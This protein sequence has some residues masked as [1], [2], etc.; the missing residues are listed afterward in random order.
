MAA[1]EKVAWMGELHSEVVRD[2]MKNRKTLLDSRK[3]TKRDDCRVAWQLARK[4]MPRVAD[5]APITVQMVASL[6]AEAA[7]H[8]CLEPSGLRALV[9]QSE[10]ERSRQFSSAQEGLTGAFANYQ[11]A[12]EAAYIN[13]ATPGDVATASWLVVDQAAADGIAQADLEVLAGL[14]SIS[15]SSAADWYRFEQ[16]GG[17]EGD[18]LPA[19]IAL[20]LDGDYWRTVGICDLLGAMGGAMLGGL[21]GAIT[22]GFL[23]SVI[24]G[25]ALLF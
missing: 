23:A 9:T 21:G 8:G 17:F 14:A 10:D 18:S 13:A 6:E 20:S 7:K 15:A 25:I 16:D 24:C 12:L 11:G 19:E 3:R 1:R 4:Y 22:G 5:H 2:L